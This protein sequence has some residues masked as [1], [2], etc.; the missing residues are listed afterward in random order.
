MDKDRIF[1][2]S[3]VKAFNKSS[4][5]DLSMRQYRNKSLSARI[6]RILNITYELI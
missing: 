5:V 2:T 3:D 4:I 6:Y 1:E